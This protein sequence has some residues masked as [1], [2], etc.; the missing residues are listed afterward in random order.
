MPRTIG[1]GLTFLVIGLAT[2]VVVAH[3]GADED[4]DPS[5]S[6]RSAEVEASATSGS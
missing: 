3:E 1:R 2:S 4:V 6:D 5:A